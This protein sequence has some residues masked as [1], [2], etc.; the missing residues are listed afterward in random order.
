LTALFYYLTLRHTYIS[1]KKNTVIAL[2]IQLI[3][4]YYKTVSAADQSQLS[5]HRLANQEESLAK[6]SK[7]PSGE[8]VEPEIEIAGVVNWNRPSGIAFGAATSLYERH[9]V[10]GETAGNPLADVSQKHFPK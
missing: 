1:F 8:S 5:D 6:E 2:C 9:P 10:S 7:P 4:I 3:L